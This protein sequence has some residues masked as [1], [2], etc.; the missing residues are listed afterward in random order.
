MRRKTKLEKRIEQLE[1]EIAALKARPPIQY[2]YHYAQPAYVPAPISYVPYQPYIP[3]MWPV[4]CG[5]ITSGL[6][7][8][9]VSSSISNGTMVSSGD[10]TS[11]LLT[12][13]SGSTTPCH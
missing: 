6:I 11:A 1:A 8:A 7:G 10:A 12:C 5:G 9:A 3:A 4:T 13:N 2:H